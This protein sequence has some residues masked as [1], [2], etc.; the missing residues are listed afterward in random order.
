MAYTC[1]YFETPEASLEDAQL[2]KFEHVC[3]KLRLVP[4]ERVVE[5]GCG[6]GSFALH[7]ARH[8]GVHVTAFNISREQIEYAR[9]RAQREELEDRVEFV[10]D[11]Y[12]NIRGKYDAFVSIGMLEHVGRAQYRALGDVIDGCLS[13]TGRGLLHSIGRT[14]PRPMNAW[15]EKRIFPGAYIP[16]LAEMLQVLEPWDLC[17]LDVEDLRRHYAKTLGHW[18]ERFEKH[19]AQI[20]RRFDARFVRTWRLY[21]ASSIA[22]FDCGSLQLFQ[23]LFGR[24][25][26]RAAWTRAHVY[27]SPLLAA[28]A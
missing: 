13:S 17:A 9:E 3:R 12:R 19:A 6:W 21:L 16:S 7:M 25:A 15:I 8:H 11:D 18:L 4:G 26:H 28:D 24:A 22:A 20:E 27:A 23:L 5:A 14:R 1:A 2:A 10:A